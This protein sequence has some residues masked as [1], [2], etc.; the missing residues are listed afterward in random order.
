MAR[1]KKI[2]SFFHFDENNEITDGVGSD[3]GLAFVNSYFP[4]A[5]QTIRIA[6][7]YFELSGFDLARDKFT[8]TVQLR[9]LVRI[10]HEQGR[11]VQM[12]VAKVVEELVADLG[13]CDQPL[14]EAVKTILKQMED[15]RFL[16]RD[17]H[18][19]EPFHCKY[20]IC[21][22]NYLWQGSANFT[23]NGLCKN[24]E[25]ASLSTNPRVIQGYIKSFDETSANAR[26]LLALLRD[27]LEKWLKL[28][29]PY[30]IY[31]KTLYLLL[32]NS[33]REPLLEGGNL[34]AY[35]QR[36]VIEKSLRQIEKFGGSLIVAATGLGKTF[37]GAEI[38][39]RLRSEGK[40]TKVILL[41]PYNVLVNWRAEC[42]G[43]RVHCVKPFNIKIPFLKKS[44]NSHHKISLLER[45]FN[46]PA[47]ELLII[48]DEA[49][50][51]RNQLMVQY[52]KREGKKVE[53]RVY[54]LLVPI[55]EKGAK[56][57]LLTATAYS[58][59]PQDIN[60]LLYL[61]PH[62]NDSFLKSFPWRI[63][64]TEEFSNLPAVCIL[65]LPHVLGMARKRNDVDENGRVYINL[66]DTKRYLPEKITL[67][68]KSYR[69][70]L[71]EKLQKAFDANQFE[72]S[73][74]ISYVYCDANSTILRRGAADFEQN[75]SLMG[76]LSSPAAIKL[77]L[78]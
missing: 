2:Q 62:K 25:N 7:G 45:E 23:K 33:A 70:P 63:D 8:P 14:T 78:E 31:L 5:F 36:G 26:D 21:D 16:I 34:P 49:H 59:S 66:G 60:G 27:R 75:P 41:A 52:T 69:L 12:A 61:L 44:E 71:Q 19:V 42:E 57:V 43:R 56:V 32:K 29:K 64:S 38:A 67:Y 4:K 20:Y 74:K 58:K 9:I 54:D 68:R 30:D 46:Y 17:A 3:V 51:Y 50:D 55:I 15:G 13:K 73:Q 37:I 18:E 24:M 48:V 28:S 40:I 47:N 11:K 1:K 10:Q 22:E 6:S 35:F 76:W 53:S 65:G 77:S 39:H 72:H